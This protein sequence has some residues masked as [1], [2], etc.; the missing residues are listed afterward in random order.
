MDKPGWVYLPLLFTIASLVKLTSFSKIEDKR[1]K[2]G[3]KVGGG[4]L[5]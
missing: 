1:N 3:L 4:N 2:K 5:W